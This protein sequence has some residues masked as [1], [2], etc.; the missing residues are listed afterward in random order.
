MKK[1]VV[2]GAGIGGMVSAIYLAS[3]GYEVEIFEKN[4]K[5]GG[6]MNEF[7]KEGFRFDTGPSLITMPY[8]L[9]KFFND[10]NRNINAYVDLIELESSCK[11]FWSDGT[12]FNSYS[13]EDKLRKELS[14]VFGETEEVNY[15]R[16]LKYGKLFYELSKENF[17]NNDFKIRNY[18]S[19]EGL[20]N[21]TKFISGR[22][23]NDVSNK[24]FKDK[25]LKQLMDRYATYNGSSPYL[26][27]QF[28]SIIPYVENEFGAWY[29]K[30]GIYKL[31][32]ALEI[33]CNE[34]NVPINYGYE[35]T[36][37]ETGDKKNISKLIFKTSDS[38]N[39][40]KENFDCLISNFTNNKKLVSDN[41]F[42]NDDW[43]CSGFVMCLGITKE[44]KE[45]SHHNIL[46]SNNYEMEFINIFEKKIPADDMTIYI[47]ITKKNETEDAPD[48]C[49]NWFILVNAPHLT[50]NFEW[51]EENKAKYCDMIIDKIDSFTYLFEDSI[52]NHIKFCEIFTPND[53]LTNYNSE[54]G[55]IYGLSS[56]SLYTLMKRPR[57][58]SKKFTNLFFV[59][60]NTHPGGGIPLCFLSGKIVSKLV[61]KV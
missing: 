56:N 16:Y 30:T 47:C 43:S 51:T 54:F 6:K 39:F 24:F 21:F 38:D 29:I 53:F 13:N 22:S 40:Q 59:G 9:E 4:L 1:I 2:C 17:L 12:V 27:P 15:F 26:A 57:N 5:P 37:I 55:S 50:K 19:K 25:R 28:F 58:T 20:K 35:L 36:D 3:K 41:Y 45:L 31:A 60:G 14:E 8:I 61:D 32:K 18:I 48:G 10:I 46:F 7:H 34:F 33:L 44:Y 11:Y 52:K 49:H 42:E 23:V